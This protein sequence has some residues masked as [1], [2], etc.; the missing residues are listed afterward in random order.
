M[1]A[2]LYPKI[3]PITVENIKELIK[4]KFYDGIIF[5]RVIKDFMIQTGDPTGTGMGDEYYKQETMQDL[6]AEIDLLVAQAYG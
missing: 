1:I 5:H 3:A 4:E 6:R 2:E